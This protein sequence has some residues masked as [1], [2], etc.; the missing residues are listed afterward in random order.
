MQRWGYEFT[1]DWGDYSSSW[2]KEAE[3][4][5]LSMV[6]KLYLTRFRYSQ[7]VSAKRVR[8][9]RAFWIR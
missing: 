4:R 3:F 9:L 5:L 2:I 7:G 6:A 1:A 8:L